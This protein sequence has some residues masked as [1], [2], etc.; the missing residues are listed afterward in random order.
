MRVD[1]EAGEGE[2]RHVGAADGDKT[3]GQHPRDHGRMGGGRGR[4]VERARAG[5]RDLARDIEQI[6]QADGNAGV[7]ARC[8]PD[9][10]QRVHRVGRRARLVG[11]DG[12]EHA[13]PLAAGVG[14]PRQASLDQLARGDA[15]G[16]EGIGAFLDRL[17]CATLPRDPA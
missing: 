17:H 5:A 10:T 8:A 12:D 3:G 11:V 15:A 2:L 13:A 7:A 6:L 16:F 9:A 4:V 14:D 1:A